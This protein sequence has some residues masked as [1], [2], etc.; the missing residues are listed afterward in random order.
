MLW[1]GVLKLF[2]DDA[3]DL[4]LYKIGSNFIEVVETC[5]NRDRLF[6]QLMKVHR[7]KHPVSNFLL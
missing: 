2:S 3:V 7:P 5:H 6:G 4:S 1:F